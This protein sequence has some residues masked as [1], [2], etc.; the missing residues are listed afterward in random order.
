MN[1]IIYNNYSGKRN[2]YDKFIE[3]K[4]KLMK[5]SMVTTFQTKKKSDAL[6][7]IKKINIVPNAIFVMGGDGTVHE[8]VNGMMLNS[9]KNI[10][11]SKI[12]HVPIGSGNGIS[13]SLNI[14]NI[15]DAITS[16][17]KGNF[18]I[19]DLVKIQSKEKKIYSV[20]NILVGLV[21][22]IDIKS[23][24]LRCLGSLRFSLYAIPMILQNKSYDVE[25][26]NEK[27]KIKTLMFSNFKN[28]TTNDIFCSDAH[29]DDSKLNFFMA[30]GNM[31][32][33]D[34][35]QIFIKGFEIS[36]NKIIRDTIKEFTLKYKDGLNIDGEY[37][38]ELKDVKCE[39]I[40]NVVKFL[41]KN[42]LN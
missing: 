2:N 30:N 7:Y 42:K 35:L 26:N 34:L 37:Y 6:N 21:S 1:L 11:E 22:D 28:L 13:S 5:L 36:S 29:P 32:V 15:E 3:L 39:V 40:P 8:V 25:F 19:V 33:C 16:Y 41:Y 10:F 12:C 23:E 31:S 24:W 18:K 20:I 17:K 9:N 14:K 38:P 4:D 27:L